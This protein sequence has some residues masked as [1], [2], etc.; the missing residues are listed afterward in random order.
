M[1]TRIPPN[2][3]KLPIDSIRGKVLAI[4]IQKFSLWPFRANLYGNA[5]ECF[6]GGTSAKH[7][8]LW[9]LQDAISGTAAGSFDF[10]R[11]SCAFGPSAL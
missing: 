10:G 4:G 8:S 3:T 7:Y 6:G 1:A 11:Q 5:N 2:R 9:L